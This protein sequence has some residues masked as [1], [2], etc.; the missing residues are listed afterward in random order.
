VVL[1]NESSSDFA[2]FQANFIDHFQ[3]VCPMESDLVFEIA[4]ARW[5]LRRILGIETSIMDRKMS[6]LEQDFEELF[7]DGS[8]QLRQAQ[9]F[10]SLANNTK[11]LAALARYESSLR[12]SYEKA[13]ADLR[14][15][16]SERRKPE[17]PVQNEPKPAGTEA[18]GLPPNVTNPLTKAIALE[19]P[20]PAELRSGPSPIPNDAP[21]NLKSKAVMPLDVCLSLQ[22]TCH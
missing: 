2:N 20:N 6:E 10:E 11:V 18:C 9:A 15:M 12:R 21:P 13:V 22:S 17:T 4:A 5:R 19:H 16:Q 14:R 3:P 8:E 1:Q 7:E